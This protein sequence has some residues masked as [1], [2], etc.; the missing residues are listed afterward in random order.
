MKSRPLAQA[1]KASMIETL[2]N[3][4]SYDCPCCSRYACHA[5]FLCTSPTHQ[6][7]S[8]LQAPVLAVPS[9]HSISPLDLQM[10]GF[11]SFRSWL[12]CHLLREPFP[13]QP[14]KRRLSISINYL[15]FILFIARIKAPVVIYLF[16]MIYLFL[17]VFICLFVLERKLRENRDLSC[18]LLHPSV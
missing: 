6:A 13:Y 18:L 10:A 1:H 2:S 16:V 17:W 14:I 7:L 11:V 5:S 8:C 4:L 9:V 3:L 12:K 15:V